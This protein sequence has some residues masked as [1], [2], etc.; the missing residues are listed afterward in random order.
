MTPLK[1]YILKYNI[2]EYNIIKTILEVISMKFV[3]RDR[4]L[5]T[6]QQEYARTS[7]SMVIIYG[8]RRVG[9]TELIRHFIED[10]PSLYFLATEESEAM[11]RE[12]FQ[13]L[14]A[15]FLDN[16]LLRDSVL[17]RWEPIFQQLAQAAEK[18]RLIIVIDEFQYIGKSDPAFLSVFQRIWDTIL[19]NAN[20]M[21]IL[22]GSL[23]SMMMSQTLNQSSP[24]YGRR[25]AQLHVR[26][27]PFAHYHEFFPSSFSQ[28]E[29]IK[30]Y[31]ITGGV[32]KYIEMFAK[33]EELAKAVQESILTPSSF[34]FDEPTFLLQ[35]EVSDIGSYFSILRVIAAGNHKLSKIAAMLQQKQT[36]LPRYLNVLIDLDLLVR[37][38]PVTENNPAKSKKGIYQIRDNFIRFWF[39]FIYPNRSYLEM[40]HTDIVLNRLKRNFID[41][42]V[43]LVYEQICQEKLW[44][45]SAEGTFPGLLERVGRWWDNAHEIDVVGLSE[46]DQLLVLGECKF[47]AGPVGINVLTAL[48]QKAAFVDWHKETRTTMY[49]LFSIHGFNEDLRAAAAV[50]KDILLIS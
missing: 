3:D 16:D 17:T 30:R 20:I 38:V 50:R 49:I 22:C 15:D 28:E 25:T 7:S 23:V 18:Q 37:D 10:K 12:A 13:Q 4:E 26:P 47:W 39:Q 42:Q 36:N 43:S 2:L 31:S 32:P 35:K 29:L 24:L 6:L 14:T 11:N 5:R 40:G 9:K 44:S 48:E 41:N 1:Y 34:L 8:R 33:D 21:L 46:A 45:L 19:Q 27:I